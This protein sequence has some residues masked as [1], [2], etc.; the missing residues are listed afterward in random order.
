VLHEIWFLLIAVLW[1]G[2]FVL[3]GFDFGLGIL[4]PF[5]GRNDGERR[6]LINAIGPVWT[7]TRSGC[8]WRAGRPSPRSPTGTATLFSGFYL[9]LFSILIA[10]I[11]R[12]V[13]FEYR[14]RQA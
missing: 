6:Q 5:I 2:Y 1:I 9:A 7:A 12:G 3:E 11:I 4:L 13:A 8:W 14:R 10:L